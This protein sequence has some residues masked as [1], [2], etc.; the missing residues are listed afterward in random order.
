MVQVRHTRAEERLTRERFLYLLPVSMA[1]HLA[2]SLMALE[3]SK[4]TWRSAE[5]SISM[6]HLVVSSGVEAFNVLNHPNF[7]SINTTY[8]NLQ[9]GQAT[10]I[11]SQS[12]GVLSPL[13]QMGG[14]RSLQLS[15]R[16][17]FRDN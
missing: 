6:S 1:M 5:L 14:P 11:L 4:R 12:L 16:L 15:L 7:G 2:T 3:L 17:T 9:F 8:G 13:Y 10:A